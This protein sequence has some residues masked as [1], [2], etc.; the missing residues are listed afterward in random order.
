MPRGL[1][2]TSSSTHENALQNISSS[3]RF[4]L[5]STY[6][7]TPSFMTLD[8]L[9]ATQPQHMRIPKYPG[10]L[11]SSLH[12]LLFLPQLDS[13]GCSPSFSSTTQSKKNLSTS[14][15]TTVK[16]D[17]IFLLHNSNSK[18]QD[19]PPSS[20]STIRPTESPAH[21]LHDSTWNSRFHLLLSLEDWPS[22]SAST[23]EAY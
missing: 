5:P 22:S 14:S 1:L 7:N 6:L 21:L 9:L 13:A 19:R 4:H 15:S 16:D 10:N 12:L 18:I 17:L 8:C 2:A 11:S 3:L 20:A 23:I